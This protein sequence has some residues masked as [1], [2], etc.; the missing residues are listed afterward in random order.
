M[1]TTSF[2]NM[3]G[4][5][6]R[7][8]PCALGDCWVRFVHVVFSAKTNPVGLLQQR[9]PTFLCFL[10]HFPCACGPGNGRT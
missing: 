9:R 1:P 10:H 3:G 6:A 2:G 5:H 4:M 8:L 7:R